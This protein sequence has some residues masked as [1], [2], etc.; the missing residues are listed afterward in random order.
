MQE[1]EAARESRSRCRVLVS[2]FLDLD[3]YGP[4]DLVARQW[5]LTGNDTPRLQ[6]IC[7]RAADK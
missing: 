2:E 6:W 3:G 4:A 5:V 7:A 1:R